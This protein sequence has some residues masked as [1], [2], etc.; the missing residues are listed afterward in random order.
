MK[1]IGR[2][3]I[4]VLILLMSVQSGISYSAE[5]SPFEEPVNAR[6]MHDYRKAQKKCR[7]IGII[8]T[9]KDGKVIL[10]TPGTP[11]GGSASGEAP[12]LNEVTTKGASVY[13]VNDR[14][15]IKSNGILH[16]FTLNKIKNK[17]IVLKGKNGR[18]YEVEAR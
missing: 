6:D 15:R 9:E 12:A 11:G 4:L 1:N 10:H 18:S 13:S 14:I 5:R 2:K 3:I 17:G 7:I 8:T 16:E